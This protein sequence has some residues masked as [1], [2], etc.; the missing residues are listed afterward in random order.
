MALHP[1]W[2]LAV[3]ARY[4]MTTGMPRYEN[5]PGETKLRIT[6]GDAKLPSMRSDN[7]TWDDIRE[8]RRRWP[9]AL[10][11]KGILRPEDARRAVECG[12]D[13]VVVSN[14]GGRC[15]DAAV[16]PI[17]ALPA[18]ADAIGGRATVLMDGGIR[19]G[20]D[21]VK[22]L[23]LGASGVLMGRPGLFGTALAG[24]AGARHV[25]EI[26][27]REMLTAMAQIGCPSLADI[28]PGI[29]HGAPLAAARSAAF[30]AA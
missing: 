20:T 2:L 14:H 16:A 8:L 25:L 24:E 7:L 30:E 18:V 28:G 22:A 17:D 21:V 5:Q 11:V 9:R 3:M 1:R 26:V 29:I 12:A 27:R 13:G 19:R 4:L 15:L 6:K 23:A 10:V